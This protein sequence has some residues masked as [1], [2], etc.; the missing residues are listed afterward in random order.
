MTPWS[1]VC[2]E[3]LLRRC[4]VLEDHR[5]SAGITVKQGAAASSFGGG[6]L[7]LQ[8]VNEEQQQAFPRPQRQNQPLF[9]VEEEIVAVVWAELDQV[10]ICLP[11]T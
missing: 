8:E 6:G 5:G 4:R 2:A 7:A 11:R 9:G 10:R 3:N 1:N